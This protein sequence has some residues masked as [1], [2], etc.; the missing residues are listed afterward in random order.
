MISR[1]GDEAIDQG[2]QSDRH[3]NQRHIPHGLVS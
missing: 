2:E 1:D 3:G